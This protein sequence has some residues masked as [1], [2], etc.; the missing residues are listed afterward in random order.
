M[1]RIGMRRNRIVGIALIALGALALIVTQVL[2]APHALILA[3]CGIAMIIVWPRDLPPAPRLPDMPHHSHAGARADLS[4]LSWAALERDGRVSRR[5]VTR[6]LALTSGDPKLSAMRQTVEATR[7]PTPAQVFRWLD[8][9]YLI[10]TK[11]AESLQTSEL[12]EATN[13]QQGEQ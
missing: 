5:V 1:K 13:R 6:I 8:A 3:G 10:E 7:S 2:D 4:Y 11:N 9:I 12:T